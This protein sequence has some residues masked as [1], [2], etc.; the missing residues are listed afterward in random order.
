MSLIKYTVE[1][2]I[3]TVVLNP[4]HAKGQVPEVDLR[5]S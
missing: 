1:L 5:K 4:V 2:S 3:A